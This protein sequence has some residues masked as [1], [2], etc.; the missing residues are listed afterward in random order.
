AGSA[1]GDE[2]L[3]L[4]GGSS[5]N[6]SNVP[7]VANNTF[8]VTST[9]S[10]GD[11]ASVRGNAINLSGAGTRY[12]LVVNNAFLGFSSLF[13]GASDRR[14]ATGSGNNMTTLTV[15]STDYVDR[16]P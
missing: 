4:G 3:D 13:T 8:F 16:F 11:A 5:S 9:N 6:D 2:M 1:T 10:V 15:G 14:F 7:V 12:I